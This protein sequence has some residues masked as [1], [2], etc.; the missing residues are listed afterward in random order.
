[1]ILFTKRMPAFTRL[2]LALV[3]AGLACNITIPDELH[4]YVA[5]DGSDRNP[6][7]TAEEPCLTL[8]EALDR[9]TDDDIIHIG[10]GT[11]R[12]SPLLVTGHIT[13]EGAGREATVID[14]DGGAEGVSIL[15]PYRVLIT[16]LAIT[17]VA[18]TEGTINSCLYIQRPAIRVEL[19][20]VMITNCAGAGIYVNNPSSSDRIELSIVDS[21]IG[22]NAGRGVDVF[23]TDLEIRR[24]TLYENDGQAIHMYNSSLELDD[25]DVEHNQVTAIQ[26]WGGSILVTGARIR[27]N[28]EALR[29]M[30]E[31]LGEVFRAVN[32][33]IYLGHSDEPSTAMIRDAVIS[34]NID[35]I[36]TSSDATLTIERTRIEGNLRTGVQLHSGTLTMSE[37]D[38]I[39][40]GRE[41]LAWYDETGGVT[42]RGGRAQIANSTINANLGGILVHDGATLLVD[43]STISRNAGLNDG[44][45]TNQ[46]ELEILSSTISNNG[47]LIDDGRLVAAG[48]MNFAKL[49]M[50]N[51]TISGNRGVGILNATYDLRDPSNVPVMTLNYVTIANNQ[52]A[53]LGFRQIIDPSSLVSNNSLIAS[54][55]GG[56]CI[57]DAAALPVWGGTNI[58]TDGSCGLGTTF[59]PAEISLGALRSNGGSTQTHALAG[60]SF[61]IDAASGA[62]ETADQRDE[63]RPAAAEDCD[64]GAYETAFGTQAGTMT[65]PAEENVEPDKG[66]DQVTVVVTSNA[67]CRTGPGSIYPDYEF[68][69][70]GDTSQAVGRSEKA[71]W[72]LIGSLRD[73]GQC[74]IGAGVLEVDADAEVILA[75][76]VIAPPPTP[77]PTVTPTLPPDPD[78][79]GSG[80]QPPGGN[81]GG[82]TTPPT[83]PANAYVANQICTSQDYKVTLAWFDAADNEEGYRIY[84][85]GNLI[86]TLGAG[87]QEYTDNPPYGGPYS[88]TIEA[89]NSAGANST[90]TQDPGCLA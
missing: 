46:G 49:V 60:G 61:A 20:H 43:H 31:V 22:E 87:A 80:Q 50:K 74:W 81:Q 75:L 24:S 26:L 79:G 1:M 32:A 27:N 25:S 70:P 11:F 3:L 68:L 66:A 86:A 21:R 71:D 52:A 33:G 90:S 72:F 34:G 69:V 2:T 83:A 76:A 89:F 53:G 78:E 8:H 41:E 51:S 7:L 29:T 67:R 23:R 64:V 40:N 58:D 77:I 9:A 18:A 88:Y 82:A 4:W 5:T 57:Y 10:P 44:G 13:I 19:E 59:T 12:E 56:D 84:R 6:C 36:S 35:G 14:F 37:V 38:V 48:I 17:H 28:G 85:D 30:V 63:P 54:N 73:D 47:L 42:V 15:G 45:I 16:D 62:C 55:M 39:G 65:D